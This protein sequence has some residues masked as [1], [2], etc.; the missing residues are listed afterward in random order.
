MRA[1]ARLEFSAPIQRSLTHEALSVA[2][3]GALSGLTGLTE[4]N[5]SGN[6]CFTS[7]GVPRGAPHTACRF[8]LG[9]GRV[10]CTG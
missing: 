4:L 7:V 6:A 8:G 5:L 1:L 3:L 9:L 2:G 10:I